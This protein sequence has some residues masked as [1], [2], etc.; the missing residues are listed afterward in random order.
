MNARAQEISLTAGRE[1]TQNLATTIQD[2]VD[3]KIAYA[4]KV[5]LQSKADFILARNITVGGVVLSLLLGI[6]LGYLLARNMLRQLGDEPASLAALALRI[7]GG[8]LNAQF[9]PSRTEIGVFGAMKQMVATL[10][11]KIAEADQKSKEAREES[12]RAR[13]A[14]LEAE[15]ARKQAERAK[16]E[17]MNCKKLGGYLCYGSHFGLF[18]I[19]TVIMCDKLRLKRRRTPKYGWHI[20]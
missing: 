1:K 5:S 6:G 2:V 12:E 14:T 15:A 4:Q 16:A 18:F 9:N 13:Q 3:T 10:K 19:F 20:L 7:A 11:G 17:G 8:D